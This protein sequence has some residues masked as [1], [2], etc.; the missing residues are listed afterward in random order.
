MERTPLRSLKSSLLIAFSFL[1]SSAYA[2]IPELAWAKSTGG[3]T[4]GIVGKSTAI[5]SNGDSYTTGYFNGTADF[6]PG[7]GIFEMSANDNDGFVLKLDGN[8][9]FVWAYQFGSGQFDSGESIAV[10]AADNVVVGG[11]FAETVNFDPG[12]TDFELTSFGDSFDGVIIKLQ[13]DGTFVFA[14][15]IGGT[16]SDVVISIATDASND[17]F[18]SGSFSGTADFDPDITG[19]FPLTSVGLTDTFICKLLA[20]GNFSWATYFGESGSQFSGNHV[21]IDPAGNVILISQ[22]FYSPYEVAIKKFGSNGNVIWSRNYGDPMDGTDGFFVNSIQTDA[23]GNIYFLAYTYGGTPFSIVGPDS[24][25]TKFN[26]AGSEV[27]TKGLSLNPND[28]PVNSMAL[29]A[30]GNITLTGYFTG[31]VDADPDAGVAEIYS[32]AGSDDGGS[33]FVLKLDSDANYIWAQGFNSSA[34]SASGNFITTD[35]AG[36][37]YVLGSFSGTTQFDTGI[38]ASSDLTAT[39]YAD[40]LLM[41][42]DPTSVPATCFGVFEQPQSIS[43]CQGVGV[44]FTALAGGTSRMTY[45]WQQFNGAT[46]EDIFDQEADPDADPVGING[47]FGANTP[48]LYV[49]AANSSGSEQYRCKITGDFVTD[50][51]SDVATLTLAGSNT[52]PYLVANSGCGPGQFLL[53]AFGDVDGNFKW[54][55]KN[56]DEISGE[57]NSTFTTPF[58]STPTQFYVIKGNADC[59]SDP[60]G[61]LVNT[62]ACAPVPGLVWVAQPQVLTGDIA[63]KKIVIDGSGNIYA[64]GDFIGDVDFDLSNS[65]STQLPDTRENFLLKMTKDRDVVWVQS[66][67]STGGILLSK[68]I[69]ISLD[70][71]GGLYLA[72]PFRGVVDFDPGPPVVELTATSNFD[73]YITKFD[74]DGNFIWAKGITGNNSIFVRSVTSDANG[75]YTT[76]S[77]SGTVDFDPNAGV[78]NRSSSGSVFFSDIFL[79]KLDTD[80]NFAWAHR[81]G[82][83]SA[84]DAGIAIKVDGSGN[85]YST[86]TFFSTVDFDPGPGI[87]NL[88]GGGATDT[89]I[90]KLDNAGIFQW[91]RTIGGFGVEIPTAIALDASGNPHITGTFSGIDPVDF[92]PGAGVANLVASEGIEFILKL[93]TNGDYMW[94]KNFGGTFASD[95][96][97]ITV[98]VAGNVLLTSY[99]E[100]LNSGY[101]FDPG[102]AVY[103]IKSNVARDIVVSQLDINGNFSWAFNMQSTGLSYYNNEGL[104]IVTDSDGS[105]YTA[106]SITHSSDLDPGNCTYPLFASD[107]NAFIQK[108]KPGVATICFNLQPTDLAVCSG[109]LID[110]TTDA[111]G[112]SNITYQWQKLNT[113]T[114]LYE[115]VI[116]ALGY[117]GATSPNLIIDTSNNFGEGSYRCYV[118][119][120]NS[121]DK[122]SNVATVAFNVMPAPPTVASSSSCALG[123]QTLVADLGVAGIYNWYETDFGG[124]AIG[125]SSTFDTPF[126]TATT[127]YYVSK[128]NGS[129]E[130]MRVPVDAVV[131]L[132]LSSPFAI[133]GSSCTS[134]ASVLLS[135]IGGTDG[136]YRW[137]T[138]ETD[139]IAILGETSGSFTTPSINTTTTYFVAINDGGCESQ[140]T[141]VN[142][143]INTSPDP[144][145]TGSSRCEPGTLMLTASGGLNGQYRWYDLQTGGTAIAGELNSTFTTPSISLTTTY[146][147]SIEINSCESNRI[148]VEATVNSIAKPIVTSS[149]TQVSGTVEICQGQSVLLTAPPGFSSYLWSNGAITEQVMVSTPGNFSVIVNDATSCQSQMS[150]GVIIS[151]KNCINNQSPVVKLPLLT[152]QIEGKFALNLAQYISDPDDNLDLTTLIIISVPTSGAI[153][154]IDTDSN[155]LLDYAGLPFSGIDKLTIEVCDLDGSCTQYEIHIEVV[156][157]VIVYNGISPNGDLLNNQWIIQNIETLPDTKEN[158]VSVFNRWGDSVFEIENYDNNTRIFKGINKNGDEVTS[159]IYFYKIEFKSGRKT[160]TGYLTIKK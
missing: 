55:D 62:N 48:F 104:A 2:Q 152:T 118:T 42:L 94:A 74:I 85:V 49:I 87:A 111:T 36:A 134:P 88:T 140:R 130:S 123:S 77:F 29:D 158:F 44:L 73:M 9:D 45:Q 114:S 56:F 40:L 138:S 31:V 46:F 27:W 109:A 18:F 78:A 110:F 7:P 23:V 54:Y 52:I 20:G 148:P 144:L 37:I 39:S 35:N 17:I 58:L 15:Q 159:G 142:A 68:S 136:Q 151:I 33:M 80:G 129:C 95:P 79:S 146:Y 60:V 116:D 22:S 66:L 69:N 154:T 32:N 135:A 117:S 128:G 72:G 126:L 115:N 34:L 13:A 65:L 21:E 81:I 147:V 103:N 100:G 11:Y 121:P 64:T 1:L 124:A 157:D 96:N 10:D 105:I 145:T 16:G 99:A 108:I 137:Y 53:T 125:T 139:P 90:H 30:N 5:D 14:K 61:I 3:P 107:G 57:V 122:T 6:D 119:G 83:T 133:N 149:V 101:D 153:A 112:T 141:A 24:F 63:I 127:T 51:F 19:T 75:V 67:G 92:D 160:L 71:S 25:I 28:H 8:G 113:S 120:D 102:P 82:R 131:N 41:K 76:G 86:G 12:V 132:T 50:I 98:D 47:F 84:T 93:T 156:G 89:Y 38:C 59:Q 43:A 4:S 106:G 70:G 26:S 91:A 97:D 155:L 150:D 143:A